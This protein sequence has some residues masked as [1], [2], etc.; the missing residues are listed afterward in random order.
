[1]AGLDSMI[2]GENQIKQQLRHAWQIARDHETDGP[3]LCRVVEAAFRVGKRIRTETDLN[4][5]TL[6]VGKAAVMKGEQVLGGL[7]GRRCMVIGAGKIGRT[8]ARAIA[9][10]EPEVLYILNRSPENAEALAVML[11]S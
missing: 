7:A 11:G 3:D 4:V 6:D 1:C 9:E 2:L 5:G 10:R 8:A